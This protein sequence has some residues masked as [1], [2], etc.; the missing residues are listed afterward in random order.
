MARSLYKEANTSF[1]LCRTSSTPTTFKNVS[2]WP[3]KDA[4]GKSSAVAEERTAKEACALPALRTAN[5]SRMAFSKSAG[6]GCASTKP[7]I[8]A[9]TA[10]RV[11]TSSTSKSLNFWLM[12][13]TKP[14]CFKNSL[15]AC[16]VVAK[17]VGTLTP[18]GSCE[19]ISPKLAF[20]P[21]TDS[22]SD[23]RRSSKGTANA[24]FAKS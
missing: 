10:T 6:N 1:I 19:I 16:A 20:L 3:A 4:S 24:S 12:R 14:P 8:S 11:R 2:C 21:P 7:R 5:C 9:P 22:T 17:P 15:N 18:L 13:S 23:I